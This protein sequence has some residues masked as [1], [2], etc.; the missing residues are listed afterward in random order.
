MKIANVKVRTNPKT[1]DSRLVRGTI[2]YIV[3]S[4]TTIL[5]VYAQYEA[6]KVFF[7]MGLVVMLLGALT[8]L[9]W[10]YFFLAGAGAGNVQSLVLAAALLVIGFQVCIMGVL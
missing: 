1:R 4:A 8:V 6:L 2:D 10:L 7:L 3:R 5:R 9:R